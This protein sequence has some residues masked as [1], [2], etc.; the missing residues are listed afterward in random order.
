MRAASGDWDVRRQEKFQL[1]EH[2]SPPYSS[3]EYCQ[4]S[5]RLPAGS[6]D[7]DVDQLQRFRAAAAH[8]GS[9]PRD[10]AYDG[11][12]R[13]ADVDRNSRE[14]REI[15]AGLRA[16]RRFG[17]PDRKPSKLVSDRLWRSITKSNFAC[18]T[19]FTNLMIRPSESHLGPSR[20]R[21]RSTAR[22]SFA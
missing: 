19:S 3:L 5:H 10:V 16:N 22:L 21:T 14:T 1:R 17:A 20:S 18:L 6:A 11:L 4:S 12:L 13:A 9:D 8:P 2:P 7:V 15:F